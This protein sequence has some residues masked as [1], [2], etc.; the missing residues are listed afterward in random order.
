M[1]PEMSWKQRP[2]SN[3][4]AK[5]LRSAVVIQHLEAKVGVYEELNGDLET[6]LDDMRAIAVWE[7]EP[8]AIHGSLMDEYG[9]T[10]H[11]VEIAE[12]QR[13]QA[14]VRHHLRSASKLDLLRRV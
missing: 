5:R 2:I 14:F 11:A 12:K 9:A 3:E 13:W 8:L 4:V 1:W 6:R 7:R 10:Y